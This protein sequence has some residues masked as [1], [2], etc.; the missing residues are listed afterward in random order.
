MAFSRLAIIQRSQSKDENAEKT[1]SF[2]LCV[3]FQREY[4]EIV[5]NSQE[6]LL[7]K[8]PIIFKTISIDLIFWNLLEGHRTEM[9]FYVI[10]R[11]KKDFT[12]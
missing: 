10:C 6:T 7:I 3:H 1:W 2:Y 11:G 5:Q 12:K 9:Y 4:Y 8:A